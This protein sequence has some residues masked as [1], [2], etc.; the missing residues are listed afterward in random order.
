MIVQGRIQ[1]RRG[2]GG[3]EGLDPPPP[4]PFSSDTHRFIFHSQR[5][6]TIVSEALFYA[7]YDTPFQ[8]P[9]LGCDRI[10]GLVSRLLFL[11]IFYVDFYLLV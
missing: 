10:F 5:I 1:G 6:I 9:F 7:C 2:G 11:F 3:P 4:S 8:G